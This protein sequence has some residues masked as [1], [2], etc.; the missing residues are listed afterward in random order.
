MSARFATL[1]RLVAPVPVGSFFETYYER[2][3]LR[4]RG[5]DARRFLDL[6]SFADVER[7]LSELDL[8]HAECRL[9]REGEVLPRSAY[10]AGWARRS[11][12]PQAEVDPARVV[13]EYR[14]GA[15]IVLDGLHKRWR[16]LGRLCRD[17]EQALGHACQANVYCTPPGARGFR[18]HYDDH[19]VL[20]LAVEG[21]KRWRLYDRPVPF[22]T[23]RDQDDP[24]LA[25]G[26]RCVDDFVLEPGDALYVPRGHL[27]EAEACDGAS[28]H[29]TLGLLA[30]T[31]LDALEEALKVARARVPALRRALPVG[32]APG[33]AP[34]SEAAWREALATLG[35]HVEL[36]EVRRRMAERFAGQRKRLARYTLAAPEVTLDTPVVLAAGVLPRVRVEDDAVELEFGERRLRLPDFAAAEVRALVDGGPWRPR[37]LPGDL[38]DEGR[39]VLVRRLLRE[40]VLDASG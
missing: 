11:T 13:A 18:R 39:L 6:L 15:T 25:E 26:R 36:A 23:G 33:H 19:D 10:A 14:D 40:G 3:P 7:A 35:E 21:R 27:H 34:A 2:R 32:F 31:W 22:P 5:D 9:A 30:D 24:A 17:L 29:V 38:D 28:L 37:D 20:V 12:D 16:P 4:C 8:R 1:A